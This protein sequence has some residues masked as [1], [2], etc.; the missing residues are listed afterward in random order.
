MANEFNFDGGDA[1]K[2]AGMATPT[3]S[4]ALRPQV[5]ESLRKQPMAFQELFDK[6]Q[7]TIPWYKP[8]HFNI[9]VFAWIIRKQLRVVYGKSGNDVKPLLAL[10][11]DPRF[12]ERQ[13]AQLLDGSQ[14]R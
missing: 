10:W 6:M 3:F 14:S 9:E 1:L 12:F 11:D 7:L 8:L 4:Y 2:I 5:I 13:G